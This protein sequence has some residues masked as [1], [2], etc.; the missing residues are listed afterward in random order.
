M[1]DY[2]EQQHGP[3]ENNPFYRLNESERGKIL[4]DLAQNGELARLNVLLE[5]G[6]DLEYK[7]SVSGKTALHC[8]L[9]NGKTECAKLLVEKGADTN[10][11]N[12]LG[13]GPLFISTST[14]NREAVLFLLK[15]SAD[16]NKPS[17][18]LTTPLMTAASEN[19]KEI[20]W[21]LLENGAEMHFRDCDGRTALHYAASE[22][23]LEIVRYTG[24]YPW[25]DKVGQTALKFFAKEGH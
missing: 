18:S 5:V 9:E 25:K 24:Y 19:Q 15:N 7:S 4:L 13:E 2:P 17:R 10:A 14:G 11:R 8:A 21:I 6:L 20:F 1:I 12:I 3:L 22:G 23:N 16:P